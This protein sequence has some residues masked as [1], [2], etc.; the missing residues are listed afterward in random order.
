M[1]R[2]TLGRSGLT[3]S[4]IGLGCMG[5]SDFYGPADDE[6]NL[7]VLNHAI[8]IGVNFLD[9]ADM[10]GNGRN[11]ELLSRVLETRRKEVVLATKFGNVRAS[12]GRI[13]GVDGRPEYV[14]AACEASLKRL[15][16]EHID[17]YYQHRVDPKV[18][19]EETV[20]AMAKLVE[21]GK[22]RYIGLSEASASTIR[23]AAS[24][25]PIT[26]LQSEYSLWTRDVE[27]EVLPTCRELGIGFVAYSPLGR[28]FLTGAIRKVDDLAPDDW[29]RT[30][31]RFQDE[32][33]EVNRK[34]V[35]AVTE[36]A[37]ERGCTPAQLALAWLLHQGDDI[38][39][40]PGT[41]K[42]ERLEENAAATRIQLTD[43]ELERIDQ[44]LAQHPVA[45][46]RYPEAGM[47]F[48][49]R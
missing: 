22:V 17:L 3:V 25:H 19:I 10:Y 29:R 1:P 20:G 13:I 31:P 47:A 36:I 15:G 2:R 24:V 40:I 32:N 28:G 38:V 48:V 30:N 34:L 18:P 23:R 12:D 5:M 35:E 6:Q 45:G 39:P 4:A 26:A 9:T 8:D 44:V 37:R 16:V 46:M 7:K 11:E 21:A 33:L 14:A 41:R 27:Q 42:I 49:N 43:S